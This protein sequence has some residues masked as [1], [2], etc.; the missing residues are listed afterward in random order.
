MRRLVTNLTTQ[1]A[2]R[3]ISRFTEP[4]TPTRPAPSTRDFNTLICA[5]WNDDGAFDE[6]SE[7]ALNSVEAVSQSARTGALHK[8][9][10]IFYSE[11]SLIQHQYLAAQRSN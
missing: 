11:R 5:L 6:P 10:K 4:R 7:T 9:R 8:Q 2:L 3:G 1:I